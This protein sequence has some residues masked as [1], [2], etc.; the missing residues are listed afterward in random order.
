MNRFER[1]RELEELIG[2][3]HCPE[4]F[5]VKNIRLCMYFT[6]RNAKTYFDE[7]FCSPI[8]L[9]ACHRVRALL[10]E[11]LKDI[12]YLKYKIERYSFCDD[13]VPCIPCCSFDIFK[14]DI[15]NFVDG[16]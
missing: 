9:V 15:M 10:H 8:P 12:P 4:V 14:K 16:H 2:Q 1:L 5:S 3:Y 6:D 11:L 7:M 13:D